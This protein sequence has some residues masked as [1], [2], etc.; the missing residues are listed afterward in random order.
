MISDIAKEVKLKAI[1]LTILAAIAF[2]YLVNTFFTKQIALLALVGI[3]LIFL[4]FEYL[5]LELRIK[6][7]FFTKLLRP[8]EEYSLYGVV[9]FLISS[10]ICL[11]IFDTPIAL[12]ALLMTT[13][14]DMIAAV[15]G[16][17][18]GT[19]I[20]YRNKTAVGFGTGLLANLFI[21]VI[22]SLTFAINLY[23]P[24]VMAFVA[25][26]TELLVEELDDNL[27]VPIVAG[28]VGQILLLSF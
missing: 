16:K 1:H 5:R 27:V 8:K 4:G 3:F 6:I 25:A 13:F 24:L 17:M 9:F 20:L 22:I 21:A 2:Y 18:Y 26:I 15:A 19:T 10:L 28:F 23:V 11:A 14:G 7:P 12:A